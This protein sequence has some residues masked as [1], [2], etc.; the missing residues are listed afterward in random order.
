MLIFSCSSTCERLWEGGEQQ[1]DYQ[2][3]FSAAMCTVGKQK[4]FDMEAF[5]R[6]RSV[7][8]SNGAIYLSFRI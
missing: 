5:L 2:S 3:P 6:T 8:L 4:P 7:P 1:R